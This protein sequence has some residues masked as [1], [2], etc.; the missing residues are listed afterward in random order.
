MTTLERKKLH[1][2]NYQVQ[3][4]LPPTDLADTRAERQVF[5]KPHTALGATGHWIKTLGILSPLLIGEFVKDA[6]QRWRYTRLAVVA[7]AAV[8]QG[9]YAQRIHRE[10]KERDKQPQR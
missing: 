4:R 5:H 8:S 6:E 10:R 2:S 3:N 1:M 7:T 9:L